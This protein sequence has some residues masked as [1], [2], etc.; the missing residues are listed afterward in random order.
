MPWLSRESSDGYTD[1]LP[2]GDDSD[3]DKNYL[4]EIDGNLSSSG[5]SRY[6]SHKKKST[7]IKGSTKNK[8]FRKTKVASKKLLSVAA[9]HNSGRANNTIFSDQTVGVQITSQSGNETGLT[10]D[11]PL[12][13]QIAFELLSLPPDVKHVILYSDTCGGQNKNSHVSAMFFKAMQD[14]QNLAVVDLKFMVSGHS[15]LECD[16][17]HARIEEQ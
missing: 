10:K 3:Q 15:H 17:N 5:E 7:P 6:F 8:L 16:I 11:L 12:N 9:V 1:R 2:F 13:N 14:N 4:P